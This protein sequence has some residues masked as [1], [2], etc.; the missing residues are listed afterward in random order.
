MV[1]AIIV[2]FLNE[3]PYLATTLASIARQTRQPDRLLLVDDG[4]R[5]RSPDIAAAFVAEHEYARLLSRPPRPPEADRLATAAEFKAFLFGLEHLDLPYD[6]VVKLD[7]DIELMPG[8]VATMEQQFRADPQL[9]IAGGYVGDRLPDGSVKRDE[10]FPPDYV[11]GQN[12]FYRRECLEQILPLPAIPGW[13]GV[14]V[15]RARRLGWRTQSFEVEDGDAIELR[16]TGGHDGRLRGFRR[17][18]RC[19]YGVGNHPLSILAGTAMRVG[20][21]P[22]VIGGINYFAGWALAAARRLPRAEPEDRAFKR[23]EDLKRIRELL[24]HRDVGRG[25]RALVG[26][27]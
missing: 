8:H 12:K 21:R 5:D 26:R 19:A 7:A 27:G 16:V 20:Q 2:P 17:W 1:I 22:Y 18:G 6:I 25:S 14:D 9:G 24:V 23:R 13:E 10:G 11:L 3:E 4:S 15:V